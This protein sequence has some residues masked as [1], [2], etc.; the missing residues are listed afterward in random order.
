MLQVNATNVGSAVNP[1]VE[2]FGSEHSNGVTVGHSF[3]ATSERS[4]YAHQHVYLE[5]SAQTHVYMVLSGVVG[6]YK[7]LADGRRQIVA[8]SYP[9]DMLGLDHTAVHTNSAEALSK[10][11]VRCI[12]MNA[13]D[14]LMLEEP[15]F[16]KS[17]LR[18]ASLELAETRDQLLSLGRKSAMEKLATFLL[19][20]SRRNIYAGNS[21]NT[22]YVPMKRSDIADYLGLTIETV[23]RNFTK[24]KIAGIIQLVSNSEIRVVS[25]PEL[26]AIAEGVTTG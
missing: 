25:Q 26:K 22:L 10:V 17:L 24:L 1:I 13:I 12:P 4:L 6:T 9:G 5:G 19:R 7:L 8:F 14:R 15:G 23:S 2:W 21:K 18:M 16:G 20:I 3:S 11:R